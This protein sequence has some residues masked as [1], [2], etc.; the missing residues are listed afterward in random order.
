M[1]QQPQFKRD[2]E[3]PWLLK[4]CGT[5]PFS[6]RSDGLIQGCYSL[7]ESDNRMRMPKPALNIGWVTYLNGKVPSIIFWSWR[8][9]KIVHVDVTSLL[10]PWT[11]EMDTHIRQPAVGKGYPL[12]FG[13][14]RFSPR[15]RHRLASDGIRRHTSFP[16]LILTSYYYFIFPPG[17]LPKSG[18]VFVRST[19]V[20][21]STISSQSRHIFLSVNHPCKGVWV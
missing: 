10:S 20:G 4:V 5:D 12:F 18:S 19:G 8:E 2:Q 11:L 13:N 3:C 1:K 17:L 16:S 9:W 14:P 7:S 21:Y 6:C 15:D